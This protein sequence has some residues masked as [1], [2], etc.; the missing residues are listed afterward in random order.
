MTKSDRSAVISLSDA[1]ARIPSPESDHAVTLLEHGT[2]KV[3][4]SLPTREVIVQR[5]IDRTN[6]I[7]RLTEWK[8]VYSEYPVVPSELLSVAHDMSG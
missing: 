5:P 3:K 4:L 2:L 1:Q 7:D 8:R 6:P